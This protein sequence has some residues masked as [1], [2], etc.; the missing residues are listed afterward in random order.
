MKTSIIEHILEPAKQIRLRAFTSSTGSRSSISGLLIFALSW[1]LVLPFMVHAEHRRS[2]PRPV[3][4]ATPVSQP[5]AQA[6]EIFT[7]YGPQR[8]TRNA[9]EPVNVV[10]NFSLPAD[11]IAPF[12]VL[13]ENGSPSGSN[14]VSSATLRLNGTNLYKANDFSQTVASL[15]KPVTLA[16]INTLEVKLASAQGSYLTIT[17]SATRAA[18]QPLLES[19]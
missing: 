16:A 2:G 1:S 5:R 14:R 19:V 18:N 11:A 10:E 12:S 4:P 6:T 15:T 13:V 3:S 9:G 7:V 17:F 8:F